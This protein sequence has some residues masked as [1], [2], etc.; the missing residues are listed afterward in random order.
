MKLSPHYF[1]FFLLTTAF[2]PIWIGAEL[3]NSQIFVI[4]L[5][6]YFL[7][8]FTLK[9]VLNYKYKNK[10]II[11]NFIFAL[12]IFFSLDVNIG[13]WL[14]FDDLFGY[15]KLNYLLSIIFIFFTSFII[16][17]FLKKNEKN[18]Y[19]LLIVLI[20][21]LLYNSFS[22]VHHSIKVQKDFQ[23]TSTNSSKK[24]DT[25]KKQLIIFLDEMAGPAGID[26]NDIIGKKALKS[27][28]ETY[29]M[30]NFKIYGNAYSI[31]RN[32]VEAIPNLLNFNFNDENLTNKFSG[33][34]ISNRKSKWYIKKNKFFDQN[35][36]I[37][38]NQS[39]GLDFCKH[40]NVSQCV[41]FT[42]NKLNSNYI[43]GYEFEKKDFF[44]DKLLKS[45]SIILKIF[46]RISLEFN[47]FKE[48][49][50]FS[51]QKAL[52]ENNLNQIVKIIKNTNHNYYVFHLV[53]PHNPFG[54]ELRGDK[55]CY[56]NNEK[57]LIKGP[58][59]EKEN[60]KYL[61]N[62]YYEVA[63]TNIYLNNFF[64]KLKEQELFEKLNILI[65]SDTGIGIASGKRKSNLLSTYSVLFAIKSDIKNFHD[66]QLTLSSKFLFSKYFDKNFK[67]TDTTKIKNHIYDPKKKA[68]FNFGNVKELKNFTQNK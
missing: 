2:F 12:I 64:N 59:K 68:Y 57:A 41:S 10:F 46:W 11:K 58:K 55:K 1:N 54:F 42:S 5:I 14:I 49:S 4:I 22:V 30:N 31:Y 17:S 8:I 53:V 25:N 50:D 39:L 62:Y 45:N 38:T 33:E 63:C 67:N 6:I 60:K 24:N 66:N 35:N 23:Y 9:F 61:N 27:F 28:Q 7:I 29:E 3:F 47:F 15:G 26:N 19:I 51:F 34:N 20:S 44:F 40:E 56:F 21:L 16:F 52:F 13:F 18:K 32:T 37:L 36:S 48:K 43:E 65:T